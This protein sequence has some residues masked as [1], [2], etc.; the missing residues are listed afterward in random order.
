MNRKL[1]KLGA[2]YKHINIG[3]SHRLVLS[4]N[5]YVTDGFTFSANNIKAGIIKGNNM[6]IDLDKGNVLT[7]GSFGTTTFKSGGLLF[8]D[9]DTRTQYTV[10]T[11]ERRLSICRNNSVAEYDLRDASPFVYNAS[12]YIDVGGGYIRIAAGSNMVT[13]NWVLRLAYIKQL[14][15][16][17]FHLKN[18]A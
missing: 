17:K 5:T 6:S 8:E 1:H 12:N 18:E 2:Q 10:A 15:V 14:N 9:N 7:T 11:S 13:L 3:A 4:A 16:G